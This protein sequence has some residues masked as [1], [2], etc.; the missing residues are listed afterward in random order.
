MPGFWERILLSAGFG[1]MGVPA[2]SRCPRVLPRLCVRGQ[3]CSPSARP[4]RREGTSSAEP[5]WDQVWRGLWTAF[6]PGS[7]PHG[8]ARG[9]IPLMPTGR[10][11]GRAGAGSFMGLHPTGFWICPSPGSQLR[12]GERWKGSGWQGWDP[13]QILPK[14]WMLWGKQELDPV[15]LLQ[16]G[17]ERWEQQ[18]GWS[19]TQAWLDL[20]PAIR[21]RP[22][23]AAGKQVKASSHRHFT[24]RCSPEPESSAPNERSNYSL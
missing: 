15:C 5:C 2:V 19:P 21:P 18:R 9:H 11:G 7:E 10:D 20:S 6:S 3:R 8:A 23:R 1:V 16:Q 14:A 24:P 22:S 12:S 4:A 17:W 13:A